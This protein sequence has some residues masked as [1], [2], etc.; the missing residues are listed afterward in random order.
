M[1]S[2][3]LFL[4]APKKKALKKHLPFLLPAFLGFLIILTSWQKIDFFLKR[5]AQFKVGLWSQ[6]PSTHFGFARYLFEKGQ[7]DLSQKEFE[8]GKG[9]VEALDKTSLG[10]LFKKDLEKT[11]KIINQEKDIRAQLAIVDK[12]LENMPYCWQLLL[13]K[14]I[15]SY[16]VYENETSKTSWNLAYWL[17]PNNEEVLGLGERFALAS[18]QNIK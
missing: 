7:K 5:K 12:K 8:V 6:M 1:D 2:K 15:L 16:R 11:E 10:F 4:P 17:N 13:K 3:L 18:Q 9:Q 14:A